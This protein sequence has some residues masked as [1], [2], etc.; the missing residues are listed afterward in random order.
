MAGGEPCICQNSK[1]VSLLIFGLLDLAVHLT[2]L[3]QFFRTSDKAKYS[4]LD[5]LPHLI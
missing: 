1:A 4:P 2:L 3:V 5:A